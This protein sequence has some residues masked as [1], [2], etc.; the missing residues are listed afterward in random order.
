MLVRMTT[1]A[2]SL[3]VALAM[4]PLPRMPLRNLPAAVAAVA[5]WPG[6]IFAIAVAASAQY[7]ALGGDAPR[8]GGAAQSRCARAG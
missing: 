7:S 4:L 1:M 6:R 8:S 3:L 5:G 2:Y